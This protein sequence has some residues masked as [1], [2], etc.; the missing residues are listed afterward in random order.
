MRM[1][2]RSSL[3]VRG[4]TRRMTMTALTAA[5]ALCLSFLESLIPPFPM[6]PPGA[7]PGLSNIAVMYAASLMGLL[8]ALAVVVAKALFALLTRGVTGGLMSLI[9]GL[10]STG[11]MFCTLKAHRPAF[12]WIGIGVSGAVGHN[13]GQLGGALLLTGWASVGYFPF[14]MLFALPAG[15]LSGLL[16]SV[17]IPAVT[18]LS[19]RMGAD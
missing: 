4:T 10:M 11:V 8:P 12:G 17:L 5:L 15:A 13:L 16:F 7:K 6:M 1:S 3:R 18:K 9:G 19:A 14:L 2:G